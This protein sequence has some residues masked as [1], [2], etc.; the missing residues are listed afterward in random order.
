MNSNSFDVGSK[1]KHFFVLLLVLLVIP[2]VEGFGLLSFQLRSLFS[3]TDRP[4][5]WAF[6][7]SIMILHWSAVLIVFKSTAPDTNNLLSF[8]VSY[9]GKHRIKL[10]ISL[11][12][13]T[14]IAFVA[15]TY[16]YGNT[17]PDNSL[18][19]RFLGPVSGVERI[20][21][22]FL[23]LT[24]GIC[25]EIIFRG[26]GITILEKLLKNKTA[27]LI[28]SSLAFMSLHG[29]AFVPPPL[30]IQY[31]IVGLILGWIFQK[32]RRL[33]ILILIHVFLDIL[34]VVAV[35]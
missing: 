19:L 35:P 4:A 21:F 15:P 30:L 2:L 3:F 29:I 18:V 9:F 8:K 25:E 16:L 11:G 26:Y 20:A 14:I 28:L 17:L 7:I 5:F 6:L 32:Y 22:V 33:E 34:I 23:A 13:A 1:S 10:F 24:A 31:F 12:L 27:A